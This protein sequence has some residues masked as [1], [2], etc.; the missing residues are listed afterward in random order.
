METNKKVKSS[1]LKGKTVKKKG[2][3]KST[4]KFRKRKY[5]SNPKNDELIK[6]HFQPTQGNGEFKNENTTNRSKQELDA[7]RHRQL[8][9]PQ[10]TLPLPLH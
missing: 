7:H 1:I 8:T 4:R 5:S 2:R 6:K 10:L 3:D 9:E